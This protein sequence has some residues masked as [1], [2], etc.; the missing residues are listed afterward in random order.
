MR[1]FEEIKIEIEGLPYREYMKL[2]HWLSE[3]DWETWD[4]LGDRG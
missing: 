4:E 3:H 2:M 1:T